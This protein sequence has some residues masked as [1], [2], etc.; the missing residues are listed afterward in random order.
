MPRLTAC[1]RA[2]ASVDG[3]NA[4]QIL[5]FRPITLLR[6]HFGGPLDV[7]DVRHHEQIFDCCVAGWIRLGRGVRGKAVAGSEFGSKFAADFGAV[8]GGCGA[9]ASV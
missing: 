2:I 7:L 6:R 1:R 5:P 8:R 3:A 4:E 9:Q